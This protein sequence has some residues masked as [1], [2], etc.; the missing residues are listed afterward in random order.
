MDQDH[1]TFRSSVADLLRGQVESFIA[2]SEYGDL[3]SGRAS[4]EEYASF[5]ENLARTHLRSPQLIAF[6][7]ALAPPAAAEHLRQNLLEEMGLDESRGRPH[8]DLLKDLLVGARLGD[9]L[10]MLEAEA[11][12]DLRRIVTDPLLYGSLRDIGLAALTEIVAFEYM[13]A[14]LSGRIASALGEHLRLPAPALL[15]LTHHSEA[16][17]RHAEQG[18]KNLE[19][20]VRYYG[21]TDAEALTIIEMTLQE[22]VFARRYFDDFVIPSAL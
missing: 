11:D 18:L 19:A 22:N 13:L 3:A 7:Y 15:W 21:F 10:A 12:E 9:R 5:I 2:T 16:D 6:L 17:V 1:G 14:R 8:P 4:P 20:Y